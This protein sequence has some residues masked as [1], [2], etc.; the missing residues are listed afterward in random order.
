MR[1]KKTSRSGNVQKSHIYD[2]CQTPAYALAPLLPYLP[3]R[4]IWEPAAGEGLLVE[5]LQRAGFVV[6]G[7]DLLTGDDFFKMCPPEW[8]IQ[9]TNPPFSTKYH[10]LA[11]SYD[12]GRPFALLMPVQVFGAARA[13]RLFAAYGV[14]VILLDK[15]VN[16]KMPNLGYSGKGAHFASA[17]F[18]WGLGLGQALTFAHI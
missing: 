13:Q 7:T 6:I 10:W 16:Y 4:V 3:D 8:D 15:R 1:A 18:T 11:H 2:R 12:L 14:E 9:V 5:A 17:W